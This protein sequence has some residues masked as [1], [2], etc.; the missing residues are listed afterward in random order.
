MEQARPARFHE[1][2]S[3][4]ATYQDLSFII[5]ED[6]EVG[7]VLKLIRETD[8]DV[9]SDIKLIDIYQNQMM[10]KGR[11]KSIT[12]RLT[13]QHPKRSLADKEVNPIRKKI[14]Q[15]LIKHYKAEIR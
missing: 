7:P 12:V 1:I 4:P 3:H 14:E 8:A 5:K 13:F 10:K 15:S 6:E 2:P 9:L 11:Q